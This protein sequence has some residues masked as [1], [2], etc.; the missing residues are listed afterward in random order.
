MF[1]SS[2]VVKSL[3][4]KGIHKRKV[5]YTL[6][7]C[8]TCVFHEIIQFFNDKKNQLIIGIFW[9]YRDYNLP[10]DCLRYQ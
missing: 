9:H 8:T 3:S 7:F 2:A 10:I 5:S 6:K 4:E 1:E